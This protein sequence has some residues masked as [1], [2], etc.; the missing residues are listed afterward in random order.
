[1]KCPW[2]KRDAGLKV[3]Q[4]PAGLPCA[5]LVPPVPTSRPRLPGRTCPP[6]ARAPV[7]ILYQQ[8]CRRHGITSRRIDQPSRQR[9]GRLLR[10]PALAAVPVQ[11]ASGCWRQP[12]AVARPAAVTVGAGV[13]GTWVPSA[14]EMQ[15]SRRPR[16]S[17]ERASRV[18]AGGDGCPLR[19]QVPWKPGLRHIQLQFA[20]PKMAALAI[21]GGAR[22]A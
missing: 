20:G 2:H 1:M 13:T 17:L 4:C 11:A 18:N 6:Q 19:A 16:C 9:G 10:Q 22:K 7:A 12:A 15:C 21:G 3:V 8:P 14:A 5:V